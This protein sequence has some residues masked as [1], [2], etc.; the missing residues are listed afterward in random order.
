MEQMI[1]MNATEKLGN[2]TLEQG[3]VYRMPTAVQGDTASE[4]L[5]IL[6]EKMVEQGKAQKVELPR[7]DV[8]EIAIDEAVNNFKKAKKALE[9]TPYYN[10][11]PTMRA[12]EI[13]KLEEQLDANVARLKAEYMVEL[14]TVE[15]ELAGQALQVSYKPDE[16]TVQFMDMALAQLKYADTPLE[17]DSALNLLSIKIG[18]MNDDQKLTVLAKYG[19]LTETVKGKSD[20]VDG[21]LEGIYG[22]IK[23]AN[24]T[25]EIDM[26]LRQ[27]HAIKAD[28]ASGVDASYTLY[29]LMKEGKK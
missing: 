9:E 10:E 22:K 29:K 8:K 14:E 17:V 7:L 26:K 25:A 6:A 16:N 4:G 27:L 21:I 5:R 19:Q 3:F 15:R 11:V 2:N 28:Y 18:A 20:K 12:I 24:K 23:G 13:A 1:F